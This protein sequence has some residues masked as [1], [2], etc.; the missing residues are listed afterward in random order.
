MIRRLMLFL[1]S[2]CSLPVLN[3]AKAQI[4]I[5]HI[6]AD[7]QYICAEG[8]GAT[9]DEAD[10][11]ALRRLS[12]QIWT[13]I[14]H[15]AA[16]SASDNIDSNGNINSHE[17]Q[18]VFM[19][20]FTSN[21]IPNARML[22]L[23]PEPDCKV[24]RYAHVDDIKRMIEAK[25]QRVLDYV[26]T[27]KR[28]E[29]LLQIDDA[30][31]NYYWAF[32]LARSHTEPIYAELGG[33]EIECTTGLLQKIN[34]VILDIR[35][36]LES[37]EFQDGSYKAFLKFIYNDHPVGSLTLKYDDGQ[38]IIGPVK[39]RNGECEL[40]LIK[41]PSDNRIAL[42]Y[43]YR[44]RNEAEHINDEMKAVF[45]SVTAPPPIDTR[46]N[47]PVKANLKKGTMQPVS[48][49]EIDKERERLLSE[50]SVPDIAPER[51]RDIR[52][53]DMI[54][55]ESPA[56]YLDKMMIVEHAIA[57]ND[58]YIARDCFSDL[59]WEMFETLMTKTGKVTLS[60][61][62]SYKFIRSREQVLARPC[63]VKLRFSNG[64]SFMENIV[65][66]FNPANHKIETLAFMLTDVAESNIFNSAS[67]YG[68]I[69]R[70]TILQ[71]MED[72]QTAY[73]LKRTDYLKAI[74]SK[75]AVIITGTVL[76]KSKQS[77]F[78]DDMFDFGSKNDN[79]R[80]DKYDHEQYFERL[81]KLFK[82]N[83]YYHL[84]FEDNRT[85]LVNTNGMLPPDAA[86]AI[87]IRQIYNSPSYSDCG[88][89]TLFL[90]MQG[91]QPRIEVRL[92]QPEQ[93]VV[94]KYEDFLKKFYVK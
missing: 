80:Y 55:I 62:Q 61:K 76:K 12:S 56:E 67:P 7:P 31:R 73:A 13:Y 78:K 75:D 66:R 30:L 51:T 65:F 38:S 46:F 4:D 71:F 26:A 9:F 60:G 29:E 53:V 77:V 90:N 63:K 6:K 92:W 40:D 11:D 37:C 93:E 52:R 32:M 59:G 21:T 10:S 87:Q 41:L 15:T 81:S 48:Q 19:E 35:P 23:Q 85:G 2:V 82:E 22:E 25:K 34:R 1:V 36:T 72:Y 64:K 84:T 47:V 70:Y 86:F 5:N 33:Q 24:F 44:F 16:S 79:V 28:A 83:E 39:V 88:Y 14:S 3:E 27:G 68:E 89:L 74:F 8:Y 49:K 18:E 17:V 45:N 91:K 50:V 20:T 42:F 94:L 57:A 43:E 54:E 58:P 69:S